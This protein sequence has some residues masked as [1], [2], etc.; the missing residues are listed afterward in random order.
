MNVSTTTVRTAVALVVLA[1]GGWAVYSHHQDTARQVAECQLL[2]TDRATQAAELKANAAN[3]LKVDVVPLMVGDSAA[4][5]CAGVG[6]YIESRDVVRDAPTDAEMKEAE[7]EY[8]SSRDTT[9]D[10]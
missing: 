7:S 1:G 4:T 3:N 5:R 6:V 10:P 8:W 9:P 2:K